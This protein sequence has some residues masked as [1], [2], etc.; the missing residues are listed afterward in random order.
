MAFLVFESCWGNLRGKLK[1]N[2]KHHDAARV[3]I[4]INFS[5]FAQDQVFMLLSKGLAGSLKKLLARKSFLFLAPGFLSLFCTA[6]AKHASTCEMV[7][8][9]I[10][11]VSEH[12]SFIRHETIFLVK[13][14]IR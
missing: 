4:G 13:R 1:A 6:A 5:K 7:K 12:Y 8:Q 3:V 10:S 9:L 2:E 14:A 11:E